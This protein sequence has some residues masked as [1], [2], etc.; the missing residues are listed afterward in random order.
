MKYSRLWGVLCACA[1]LSL[2]SSSARSA[3]IDG[4]FGMNFVGG[5]ID[6]GQLGPF[7][8]NLLDITYV[9]GGGASYTT[10]MPVFGGTFLESGGTASRTGLPD[11]A[12]LTATPTYTT[13]PVIG[14]VPTGDGETTRTISQTIAINW[15]TAGGF[16]LIDITSITVDTFVFGGPWTLDFITPYRVGLIP[17][18]TINELDSLLFTPFGDIYDGLVGV[19]GNPIGTAVVSATPPGLESFIG[20]AFGDFTFAAAQPVPLP[21]SLWLLGSGL[22]GL[23]GISRHKKT[24]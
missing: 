14:G 22:L 16:P 3:V 11:Y 2:I 6:S 17:P 4:Y 12:G 1:F 21:A 23:L 13:Q 20:A 15:N 8:V 10:S 18:G 9:G 24:A 19:D 5:T 7:E